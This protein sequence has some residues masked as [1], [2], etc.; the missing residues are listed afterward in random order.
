MLKGTVLCRADGRRIADEPRTA[1]PSGR[2]GHRIYVATHLAPRAVRPRFVGVT[3]ALVVICLWLAH[4][5]WMFEGRLLGRG[6]VWVIVL[7][8]LL[9]GY[10][11]TG[12]FMTAH[13][14]MHGTVSGSRVV[15]DALGAVA[16]FLFAGM[17]YRRLRVNH[18]RHHALPGTAD[19]PDFSPKS[20]FVW[21]ATFMARYATFAQ[22]VVM[23][24]LF[25]ALK[26]RYDEPS[27]WAF[28]VVPAILAALQMFFFGTYLP[29][30]LPHTDAMLPDNAR[31]LPRNDALAM[32]TCYFFGYHAE[33]HASPGTPWWRLATL[34]RS[35]SR[36]TGPRS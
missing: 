29:H 13:D 33:H 17:S 24:A 1:P 9:Q 27:L 20:F 4:G 25:N 11:T 28:W 12:L 7:H 23:A 36:A 35:A 5:I 6:P 16:C 15:N 10:L 2:R 14:A 18:A 34:K 8:V 26:I 22:I 19:D 32:V 30:R 21:F 31:T 3:I